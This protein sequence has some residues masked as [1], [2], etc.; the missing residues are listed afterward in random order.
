MLPWDPT[1]EAFKSFRDK[2]LAVLE[3]IFGHERNVAGGTLALV[4]TRE[5]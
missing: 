5:V 4:R 1:S 2:H 3:G